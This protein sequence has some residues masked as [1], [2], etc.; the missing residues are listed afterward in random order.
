MKAIKYGIECTTNASESIVMPS[1]NWSTNARPSTRISQK[2]CTVTGVRLM[3]RIFEV[4]PPDDG[5]KR[6]CV[7]QC[8]DLDGGHARGCGKQR[9]RSVVM[10]RKACGKHN[11][12]MTAKRHG[13]RTSRWEDKCKH[14]GK[15]TNLNAGRV[16]WFNSKLEA[17]AYCEG[18][19]Q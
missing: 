17:K 16:K 14:C 5:T 11:M 7:W 15:R 8:V 12:K 2:Q 9:P 13:T 10:P 3:S 19:N 18:L 1:V 6:A 4:T